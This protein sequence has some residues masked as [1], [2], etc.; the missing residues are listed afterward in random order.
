MLES[1]EERELKKVSTL[2]LD[3]GKEESDQISE[4]RKQ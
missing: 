1:F 3:R 2:H 4:L